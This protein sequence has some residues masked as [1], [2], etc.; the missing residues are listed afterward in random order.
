MIAMTKS[1]LGIATVVALVLI[2]CGSKDEPMSTDTNT[3]SGNPLT[4]PVDYL[5][6]VGKAKQTAERQV[7]LAS[8]KKALDVFYVQEDRYPTN[9]N[10]LVAKRYIPEVPALPAGSTF[11]YNPQSGELKVARK[12]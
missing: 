9:L 12:S 4:A 11:N 5:G 7:D 1:V 10:E 2:G 6:S 3:S 8:V